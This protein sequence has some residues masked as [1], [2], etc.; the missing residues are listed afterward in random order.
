MTFVSILNG[1][2]HWFCS[3]PL[4]S[5]III[6][7]RLSKE[8]HNKI[9]RIPVSVPNKPLFKRSALVVFKLQLCLQI[10]QFS[11]LLIPWNFRLHTLHALKILRMDL[12][13]ESC[14]TVHKCQSMG[15]CLTRSLTMTGWFHKMITRNTIYILQKSHFYG[16]I[17]FN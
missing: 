15:L 9:V 5:D 14:W 10:K 16:S 8:K 3:L 17:K 7:I 4:A 13:R 6:Y 2:L 12:K 11:Y 1:D